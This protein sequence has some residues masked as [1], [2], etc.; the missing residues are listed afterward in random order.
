MTNDCISRYATM[1][2]GIFSFEIGVKHLTS[3]FVRPSLQNCVENMLKITQSHWIE[4]NIKSVNAKTIP[5]FYF[6]QSEF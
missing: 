5:T 6:S 4:V 1:H 3:T 2:S